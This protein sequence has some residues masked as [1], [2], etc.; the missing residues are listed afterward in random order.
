MLQALI[1]ELDGMSVE[2]VVQELAARGMFDRRIVEAHYI[3]AQMRVLTAGGMTRTAA[4]KH[5]ADVLCCS[6][7]KVRSLVYDRYIL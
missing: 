5:L 6:Y 1:L 3:R 2:K 7:E 4:M